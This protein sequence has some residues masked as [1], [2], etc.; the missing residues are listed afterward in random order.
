MAQQARRTQAER[1][2]STRGAL[3]E[4]ATRAFA[5]HGYEATTL[6]EI[7]AA[8]SVSKG[9][10]HHYFAAKRDLVLPVFEHAT[11]VLEERVI[12]RV[13]AASAPWPRVQGA[14]DALRGA[15]D[16]QEA[17][18]LAWVECLIAARR[19]DELS[20]AIHAERARL[21]GRIANAIRGAIEETGAP[22][23][24]WSEDAARAAIGWAIGR[25]L[26]RAG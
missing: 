9:A 23:S 25:V 14:I 3:I 1:R 5:T 7:A 2:N 26:E 24:Q 15:I 10:V 8:A 21:E 22:F 20:V 16:A 19:D 4:H 13:G 18:P 6:A 11:R 12:A 17:E